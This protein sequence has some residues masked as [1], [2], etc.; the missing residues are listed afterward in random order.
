MMVTAGPFAKVEACLCQIWRGRDHSGGAS[1]ALKRQRRA[2]MVISVEGRRG[3]G[4]MVTA[5]A[6]EVV[7]GGKRRGLA[8]GDGV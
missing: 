3:Y 1:V 8:S 7:A 6:G 4:G 5:S 2:D